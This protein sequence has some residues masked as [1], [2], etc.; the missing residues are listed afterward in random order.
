M[1]N[2]IFD[3]FKGVPRSQQREA[4][5]QIEED[6]DTHDVF[7]LNLPVAV[8][9]SRVA[10]SIAKW[11]GNS[12]ILTPTNVLL[13]QYERDFNDINYLRRKNMYPCD[14]RHRC[15]S[16]TAA[17]K[18][19]EYKKTRQQLLASDVG[20]VNY[21]MYVAMRTHFNL[22]RNTLIVDEAQN[23]IPML[24]DMAAVKIWKHTYKYPTLRTEADILDWLYDTGLDKNKT[25]APLIKS[26]SSREHQYKFE[27]TTELFRGEECELIKAKPI[28]VKHYKP[29]LWPG[30]VRKIILLSAPIAPKD[31]E[32]LGLDK[33]RVSYI[34]T[35]SPIP[36]INRPIIYHPLGY[37]SYDRQESFLGKLVEF[38]KNLLDKYKTKGVLHMTYS[39]SRKLR[40][41]LQHPRLMYHDTETTREV[42]NEFL[43]SEDGVLVAC[44]LQEGIDLANDL[45]R[46]Q[47]IVKIPYPSLADSAV[48]QKA[49]LD[50][51]WYQWVTV[52]QIIQAS[53]RVCRH[54]ED[55]GVT[56][57][58]DKQFERLYTKNNHM[59]PDWFK[60]AVT[61]IG[62]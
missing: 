54:Q 30:F 61:V 40:G 59:F 18:D 2:S 37:L 49:V 9:K 26:F 5:L 55:F 33:K 4:L 12:L 52:K 10:H 21:Y 22:K 29:I 39:L 14:N 6:W 7:V 20:A 32:E 57:I 28:S 38:I 24:T 17:C 46:W 43:N 60:G 41:L 51:E 45:G 36:P 19:C 34:N 16:K 35:D 58:L 53:G 11:A 15:K 31:V 56:F 48:N 23:L 8:G 13:D 50:P 25:F 44:G 27:R 3:Y 47:A 42:Y 62:D 1:I